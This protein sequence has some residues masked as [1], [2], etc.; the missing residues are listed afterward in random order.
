[1]GQSGTVDFSI[2]SRS[3]VLFL[4]QKMTTVTIRFLLLSHWNITMVTVKK[5]DYCGK[6]LISGLS[7]EGSY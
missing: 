1:M 4:A 7:L 6:S 5:K 3:P 2:F